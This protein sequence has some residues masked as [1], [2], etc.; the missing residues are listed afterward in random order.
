MAE[1]IEQKH[2]IRLVR[3][4]TGNGAPM[5][6]A[7]CLE[8]MT[9]NIFQSSSIKYDTYHCFAI[10][11]YGPI[12][13]SMEKGDLQLWR[14]SPIEVGVVKEGEYWGIR[15]VTP[16]PADAEPD[17]LFYPNV[18]QS[19]LA[20]AKR[21]YQLLSGGAS[22]RILDTETTGVSEDDE[23]LQ[24]AI[25]GLRFDYSAY[26]VA[27]VFLQP[28]HI[29]DIDALSHIH[30]ITAETVKDAPA[31]ADRAEHFRAWLDN[32]VWLIY[33]AGF[34][35]P[36]LQ[37]SMMHT[38]NVP[39]APLAVV[40]VMQLFAQF[41]G[42]WDPI[43]QQFKPCKLSEAVEQMGIPVAN[44]HNALGDCL[45]TAGLLEAMAEYFVA[46]ATETV[47]VSVQ[48]VQA[49][50]PVLEIS[51]DDDSDEYLPTDD[52]DGDQDE[53]WNDD[54]GETGYSWRAY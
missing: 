43:R 5:W 39:F 3:D 8:G 4:V 31:F 29:L 46:H 15:S 13:G 37:R 7:T 24:L 26:T 20:A 42:E 14:T 52:D 10:S 25:V 6:R 11:G 23:I 18:E 45:M 53:S 34:D 40:C 54:P 22:L 12:L 2:I 44:A 27:D 30:G 36:L 38:G 9:V 49:D 47:N 17:P 48:Y 32:R 19:K 41:R 21:A 50:G 51:V 16:K 35:E 28:Q 33:N 1:I